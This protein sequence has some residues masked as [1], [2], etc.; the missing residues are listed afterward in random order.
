MMHAP[1]RGLVAV[2]GATGFI[3]GRV[4][5][6]LRRDGWRLRVLIR[7][8]P[9]AAADPFADDASVEAVHGPLDDGPS[10]RRLV[11]GAAA[12]VHIA[13]LVRARS[14]AEFFGVNADGVARLVEAV[15]AQPVP[16]H[17]VL[18]SSLAAR[19]PGLSAY[20]ASKRAGEAALTGGGPDGATVVPWT[21]LRPPAVYGP[22]DRQTL[23][24]FRLA[25]LG[26]APVPAS[27]AA[28]V[29]LIHADDLAA[30][31]ATVL[32]ESGA[33]RGLI[34]EPDDGQPGGYSWPALVAAVAEQLGRSVRPLRVPRTLLYAYSWL[35]SAPRLL[36]PGHR[37]ALTPDKVRELYHHDWVCDSASMT[38][39]TTWRPRTPIGPGFAGTIAWYRRH[40][41][42]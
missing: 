38:A 37:P 23:T 39:A 12:V 28:R 3:G 22:G 29:S 20:A 17:V 14:R 13:G 31:V 15:A 18:V 26:L 41:W 1:R 11:E 7:R 34:A 9:Q 4:V 33:A 32:D 42:L 2:T 8:R 40:G 30:A 35:S 10:L 16:A 27:A 5:R 21:I 19:E 36:V 24:F 6:R 25:R